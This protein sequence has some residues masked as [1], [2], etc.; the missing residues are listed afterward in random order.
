MMT[1]DQ[2]IAELDDRE[3][4]RIMSRQTRRGRVS[5]CSDSINRDPYEHADTDDQHD[6]DQF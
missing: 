6:D 1:E 4:Y 5:T 3:H 2:I